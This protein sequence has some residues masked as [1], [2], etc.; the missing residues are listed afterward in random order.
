MATAFC[1]TLPLR[2]KAAFW[3][4]AAGMVIGGIALPAPDDAVLLARGAPQ[5]I[6]AGSDGE[7]AVYV[8]ATRAGGQ[9][10]GFLA[11]SAARQLAQPVTPDPSGMNDANGKAVWFA[12]H[13]LRDGRRATVVMSRRGL[14]AGCRVAAKMVIALVEADYP[15]RSGVPL[16]SLAGLPRGNYRLTIG[17]L[18]ITAR[19]VN[20]QYLRISPVSRP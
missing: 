7:A 8:S 3:I 1:L 2:L 19:A 20:G 4:G 12:E 9:L 5:L 18:G 16:F 10:S 13:Q 11:D 17:E 6:L 15:C 14:T